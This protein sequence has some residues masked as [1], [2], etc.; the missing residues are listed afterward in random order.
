MEVEA[1]FLRLF[2]PAA[3]G[4]PYRWVGRPSYPRTAC[5]RASKGPSGLVDAMAG[6]SP[7]ATRP[8]WQLRPADANR[9]GLPV[10]ELRQHLD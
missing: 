10:P 5:I 8:G 7:R 1:K 9:A 6:I 2:K 3:L 4:Q